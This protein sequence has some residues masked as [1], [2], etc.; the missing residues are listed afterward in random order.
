MSKIVEL[1]H[2]AD[3]FASTWCYNWRSGNELIQ[4]EVVSLKKAANPGFFELSTSVWALD[5]TT[6]ELECTEE[7][8]RLSQKG[9][10]SKKQGAGVQDHE[11]SECVDVG[12]Y[13]WPSLFTE[14]GSDLDGVPEEVLSKAV[15][16][17][18]EEN[19]KG[20]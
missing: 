13:Q 11:S 12:Q 20:G 4:A 9:L 5:L 15:E 3:L 8:H 19:V 6:A 2:L 18:C 7:V 14:N 17:Y 1:E 16:K 10:R